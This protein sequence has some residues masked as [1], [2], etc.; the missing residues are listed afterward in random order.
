MFDFHNGTHPVIIFS[1]Y[2]HYRYPMSG[3][4]KVSVTVM[5][6]QVTHQNA[7]IEER[8]EEHSKLEELQKENQR[9]QIEN[10]QV[11]STRYCAFYHHFI[12]P[13]VLRIVNYIYIAQ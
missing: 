7:A 11:H 9:L 3:S 2:I 4:F 12:I 1:P 5:Q 10:Q 8:K 13:Y 6:A